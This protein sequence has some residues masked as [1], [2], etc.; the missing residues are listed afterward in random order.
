MFKITKK[1]SHYISWSGSHCVRCAIYLCEEATKLIQKCNITSSN[2]VFPLS[3]MSSKCLW[4]DFFPFKTG[5]KHFTG[6]EQMSWVERSE[7]YVP[8]PLNTPSFLNLLCSWL[9]ASGLASYLFTVAL[10]PWSSIWKSSNLCKP[11]CFSNMYVCLVVNC[12]ACVR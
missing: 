7:W 1:S 4:M 2:A 12:L 11:Q 8:K 5:M 9:W 3:F 6:R 10:W